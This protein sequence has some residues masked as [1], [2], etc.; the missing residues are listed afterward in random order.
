MILDQG[1]LGDAVHLMPSAYRVRRCFPDA[2]LHVMVEERVKGLQELFPWIDQIWGYQRHP[3]SLP[4][5]KQGSIISALRKERFDGL[6]NLN[7][8]QRSSWLSW[9]SGVP[10]RLGRIPRKKPFYW[11][12]FFTHKVNAPTDRH[13]AQQREYV[14]DQAGFPQPGF[15]Y[16]AAIPQPARESV[17]SKLPFEGSFLHISPFATQDYKELTEQNLITLINSYSEAEDSLPVVLSCSNDPREKDK[18]TR[19][20]AH[21]K[22]PPAKTFAGDLN[23]VEFCALIDLAQ[24]HWGGDSGSI[25]ISQLVDTPTLSWFRDYPERIEWQP[26]KENCHVM[27]GKETPGGLEDFPIKEF[28]DTSKPHERNEIGP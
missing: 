4:W 18:M 1:F 13:L 27:I 6:I 5:W 26:W 10:L 19:L 23:V 7:G 12:T 15:E 3:R 17:Q 8:S 25:H 2:E 9:F 22:T 11:D 21:L 14:L 28:L 16:G 24:V 20:L